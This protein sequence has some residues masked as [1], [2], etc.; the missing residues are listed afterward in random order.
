MK[1][2]FKLA[3]I[4]MTICI[5]A[6]GTLAWVE[7]TTRNKIKN[8]EIQKQEI[9]KQIVLKEANSFKEIEKEIFLGYNKIEQI[10]GMVV[11][12]DVKGYGGSIK[13]LVGVGKD[14]KIKG[15]EILSHKETPGLGSEIEKGSFKNQFKGKEVSKII[16]KKDNPNGE[17]DAIS[18]AT[19]SS[20]AVTNGLKKAL[21]NADRVFKSIGEN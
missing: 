10:V 16:L 1:F 19:I 12:I 9:L 5:W 17:I 15:F 3:F 11:G 7:S 21:N 13:M 18:G 6:A 8:N 14:R 2:I 4:L 20:R